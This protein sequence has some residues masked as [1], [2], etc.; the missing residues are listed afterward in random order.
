MEKHDYQQLGETIYEE[1]LPNGLL[2]QLLP[3]AGFHKTYALMT[4]DFGSTGCPFFGT[5]DV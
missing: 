2:V 1:T 3:K 4:T 5:Q